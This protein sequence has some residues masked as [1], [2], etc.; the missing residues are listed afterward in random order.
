MNIHGLITTGRI[1]WIIAAGPGQ[2]GREW[3]VEE[4]KSPGKYHVVEE[5]CVERDYHHTIADSCKFK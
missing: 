3:G 5:I 2:V 1:E 4:V